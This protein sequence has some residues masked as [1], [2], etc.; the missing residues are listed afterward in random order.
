MS[1]Y[2]T[3][4]A[5]ILAA[6]LAATAANAGTAHTVTL[7]AGAASPPAKIADVGW[8][9]GHWR[10]PGIGGQ[11]EEI[12]S[13]PEGGA[14]MCA[15]R[16]LKDGKVWFYEISLIAEDKGSLVLR[17]KHF[18]ADLTGWEEKAEVENSALVKLEPDAVYFDGITFRKRPDGG[19]DVYV[20]IKHRDG[21][22]SEGHFDYKRVR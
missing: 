17:V 7:A 11:A 12:W 16:V 20:T 13:A 18:N 19:M 8:I 14:M 21:S 3:I 6:A 5:G 4:C 15:F 2:R 22:V 1:I 10:G 9:T